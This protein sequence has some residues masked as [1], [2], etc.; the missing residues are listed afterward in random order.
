MAWDENE[1]PEQLLARLKRDREAL[2]AK[3]KAKRDADPS[4]GNWGPGGDEDS[5]WSTNE[6]W[7]PPG[8]KGVPPAKRGGRL[9]DSVTFEFARVVAL[10]GIMRWR[11][12]W[13]THRQTPWESAE[14]EFVRG[15]KKTAYKMALDKNAE[16][17]RED[18]QA[19]P[20]PEPVALDK[21]LKKAARDARKDKEEHD[22]QTMPRGKHDP[23]KNKILNLEGHDP[24]VPFDKCR[25]CKRIAKQRR[26]Q[27]HQQGVDDGTHPLG[28]WFNCPIC[29]PAGHFERKKRREEWNEQ[30]PDDPKAGGVHKGKVEGIPH[31]LKLPQ[32]Q[33][34]AC[35]EQL[36]RSRGEG[37]DTRE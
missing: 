17:A 33:C 35:Q 16:L 25:A 29:N 30:P 28:P 27:E 12:D 7:D 37:G 24:R 32:A 23:W 10:P 15:T 21:A 3:Y 5:F 6:G 20:R 13:R 14:F 2:E 31:D 11:L 36:R 26:E 18:K 8:A 1:T 9:P 19:G 34:P 22:K 4:H